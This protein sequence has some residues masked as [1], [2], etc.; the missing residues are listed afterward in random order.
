MDDLQ[1]LCKRCHFAKHNPDRF[2]SECCTKPGPTPIHRLKPYS[3]EALLL[4]EPLPPDNGTDADFALQMDLLE[5]Q[6]TAEELT[7]AFVETTDSEGREGFTLDP[8]K[9]PPPRLSRYQRIAKELGTSA[10][11]VAILDNMEILLATDEIEI[12]ETVTKHLSPFVEVV[13]AKDAGWEGYG[14]EKV[15]QLKK[16]TYT[17]LQK[18]KD[19]RESHE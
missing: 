17:I 4:D 6:P 13:S 18:Y 7:A 9:L 2:K 11:I 8:E 16:E 1:A 10:R 5:A 15:Y 3:D 14:Y 12:S 19:S